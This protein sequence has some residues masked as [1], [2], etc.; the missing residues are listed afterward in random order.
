MNAV[1]T[2]ES[3][4]ERQH[5]CDAPSEKTPKQQRTPKKAPIDEVMREI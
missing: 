4:E 2:E 3:K 1:A 5:E